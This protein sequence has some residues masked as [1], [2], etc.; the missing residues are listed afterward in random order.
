[1]A[2][3][4][5]FGLNENCCWALSLPIY[6][7]GGLSI[8]F[9]SL[10]SFATLFV[11]RDHLELINGIRQQ[12]I[13]HLSLVPMQL[14]RLLDEAVDLSALK[15]I[16]IGGDAMPAELKT[17]AGLKAP[18]FAT[19]GLTETAS[20]VWVRDIR[21]NDPGWVLPHAQIRIADD[22]QIRCG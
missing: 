14:K 20:M 21:K 13:T 11:A 4:G 19:Y 1:M 5:Y 12:N 2:V 9:R 15:A 22:G 17:S 10:L 3:N 16:I 7:V 8:I 18:V 6:H